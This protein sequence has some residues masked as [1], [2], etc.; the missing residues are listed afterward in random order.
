MTPRFLAAGLA[1]VVV[2]LLL[3]SSTLFTVKQTEQA[4]VLQFGQVV[5]VIQTPGLQAKLPWQN[6]IAYDKRLLDFEP[7]AE[8]V[9]AADQKR[10]V[11]DAF[12]RFR[13][14]DPLQFYQSA[15]TEDVI[16]ARLGSIMT[17]S[18]RR[19]IGNVDL[20]AVVSTKRAEIM[21][22]IRDE[23]NNEAKGFGIDVVDVRIRHADLPE[24]NSQAVYDR[25]KSERQREAAQFRAEGVKGAQEIKADADRQ[26]VVILAD[27]QKQAQILRGQGDAQSIGIYADAFGKDRGFFN[28]YR[29]LE[30]YKTS[31]AGQNTSFVLSP[32]S[33]FFRFFETGPQTGAP[34]AGH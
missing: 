11:V 7:P 23:V 18:L 12:A 5:R 28:F 16:V 13:I 20:Q 14:T 17:G 31:L 26:K 1:A 25:M 9:I 8:E 21:R 30:A 22:Q 6:A 15:G 10:L 4:L 29:S 33:D 19:V 3:L 27:A 2:L 32:E 24:E 34:A